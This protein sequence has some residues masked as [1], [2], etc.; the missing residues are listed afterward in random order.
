[1]LTFC[2]SFLCYNSELI[3]W[4][5]KGWLVELLSL[6]VF[7]GICILLIFSKELRKTEPRNLD[8]I[9]C[10]VIALSLFLTNLMVGLGHL[11]WMLTSSALAIGTCSIFAGAMISKSFQELE[12]KL[13]YS[14]LVGLGL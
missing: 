6:I 8:L 1:M 11:T 9:A 5:L 10:F 14:A 4:L 7:V 12:N 13:K 3:E 2:V